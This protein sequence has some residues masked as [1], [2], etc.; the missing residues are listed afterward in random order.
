ME[1]FVHLTFDFIAFVIVR[2][3]IAWPKVLVCT[4]TSHH[5]VNIA[6]FYVFSHSFYMYVVCMV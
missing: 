2:K 3:Q 4:V 5:N 1:N 6:D